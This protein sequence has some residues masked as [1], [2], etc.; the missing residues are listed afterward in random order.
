MPK[1]K[2]ELDSLEKQ[3]IIAKVTEPTAWVHPIVIVPKADD[4]IRICCD[5]TSLN[6][7]IIRQ[8]FE[9]PT[10]FQAVRT[11]FPG[12]KSF[13]VIDALKGYNQVELDDESSLMTTISTP[14]CHYKY[15]RLPFGVSL[16]GTRETTTVGV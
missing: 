16:A 7:C 9:E 10:P 11:I 12:M 2:R 1:V 15:L 8:I 14:F 13:M 3:N 5:F 4:E 6:R